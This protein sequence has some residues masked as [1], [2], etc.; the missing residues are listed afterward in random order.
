MALD[1]E[2]AYVLDA[3]V[4]IP[5][6]YLHPAVRGVEVSGVDDRVL[7][8]EGGQ[9]LGGMHSEVGHAVGFHVDVHTAGALS[10]CDGLGHSLYV[11][12]LPADHVGVASGFLIPVS[13]ECQ[14]VEH[15]VDIPVVVHD[16]DLR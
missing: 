8:I 11:A 2:V 4:G 7:G 3:F 15:A 5:H 12:E 6:L 13:V 14:G 9:Q 10:V 16:H 1:D